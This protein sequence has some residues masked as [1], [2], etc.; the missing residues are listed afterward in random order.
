MQ[1]SFNSF[2]FVKATL[3]KESTVK[4]LKKL[5]AAG[6]QNSAKISSRKDMAR[7]RFQTKSVVEQGLE[8]KIP[9][10]PVPTLPPKADIAAVT[11]GFCYGHN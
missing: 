1:P 6:F 8:P 4:A 3:N 9:W 7:V 10:L 2:Y 5:S 11:S